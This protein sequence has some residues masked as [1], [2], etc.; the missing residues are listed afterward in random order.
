[1]KK[2]SWY[3]IPAAFFLLINFSVSSVKIFFI[4]RFVYFLFFLALFFFLKKFDLSGII[5]FS[6]GGASF[7]IFVYGIVQ[8]FFLFPLYL[9]TLKPGNAFYSQALIS[10]IESGRVFSI[11][12]L[13][14][15]YAIICSVFII[16]ILHYLLRSRHKIFW[17]FLLL[18]GL[19]NLILTQSFGGLLYLSVG[20]L[21]YLFMS[22]IVK[23]RF[24]AP[25]VMAISLFFFIVAGLRFAEVK[26]L[27]PLK[28][29]ITNWNQAIRVIRSNPFWGVGLG[30]Y[31]SEISTHI[32]SGESRSI[33][34]HNFFLQFLGETGTLISL[35]ILLSL[36]FLKKKIIPPDRENRGLFV[37]AFFIILIYNLLDIGFYFFSSALAAVVI[38][39]QM[40]RDREETIAPTKAVSKFNLGALMGLGLVLVLGTVSDGFQKKGDFQF[41]QEDFSRSGESY[42]K[43]L[44][45]NPWNHRALVGVALIAFNREHFV[46]CER[47]LMRLFSMYP[48]SAFA[49]HLMS[50]LQYNRQRFLL[51]FYY[52]SHAFGKDRLNPQYAGWCSLIKEHLQERI[53]RPGNQTAFHR[54]PVNDAGENRL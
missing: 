23:L 39:S 27:E 45:F 34:A 17:M 24:L 9:R 15:L 8:K 14:A 51:S 52:A 33:Y 36:V 40:Y 28:L 42:R 12:S 31:Q 26:R 6:I 49:N 50:K 48:G 29:R 19:T 30:N 20:V 38:L 32:L 13:P 7:I 2:S 22:G 44:F 5:R 46:E 43:S 16:F 21:I 41:H 10:R 1:M 37:S 11:F 25:V 47:Y 4:W 54:R 35:L 18:M 53:T 3:I